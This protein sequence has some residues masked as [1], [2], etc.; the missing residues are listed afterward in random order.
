MTGGNLRM[1][2]LWHVKLSIRK[3]ISCFV[4]ITYCMLTNLHEGEGCLHQ[5]WNMI[6]HQ[7]SVQFSWW[8]KFS[9]SFHSDHKIWVFWSNILP[10]VARGL[11]TEV[12]IGQKKVHNGST[13]PAGLRSS[14]WKDR[15]MHFFLYQ[16]ECNK[17]FYHATHFF[18]LW[19]FTVLAWL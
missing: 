12:M 2:E 4:F 19:I 1:P 9:W 14:V 6:K 10:C 16:L 13:E 5:R 11:M 17:T 8:D 7:T 15:A 18:M 3:V